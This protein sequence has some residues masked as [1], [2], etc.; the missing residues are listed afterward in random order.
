MKTKLVALFAFAIV[1][2]AG[3]ENAAQPEMS[4]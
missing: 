4:K 2:P 1:G 3:A